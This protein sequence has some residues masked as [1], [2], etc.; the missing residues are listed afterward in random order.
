MSLKEIAQR[1]G[2][3]EGVPRPGDC[4]QCGVGDGHHDPRCPKA[5]PLR[6]DPAVAVVA[7]A[8][9]FAPP[10]EPSIANPAYD[11]LAARTRFEDTDAGKAY[12]KY[13]AKLTRITDEHQRRA[14]AID[15]A[16]NDGVDAAKLVAAFDQLDT[17][18]QAEADKFNAGC[19]AHMR[20]DYQKPK[21]RVDEITAQIDRLQQEKAGIM[22]T[23]QPALDKVTTVKAQFQSAWGRRS[24]ELK[25]QRSLFTGG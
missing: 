25:Q 24:T 14:T 16:A 21:N 9:S 19:D 10:A 18:L 20:D 15:L 13:Y 1:A 12:Q 7:P 8:M 2:L 5:P 6:T 17:Q 3:W 23:L 4:D 22:A 11:T